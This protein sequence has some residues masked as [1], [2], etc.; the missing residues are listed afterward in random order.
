MSLP[1]DRFVADILA[2]QQRARRVAAPAR[3]AVRAPK[4]RRDAPTALVLSP[5]PDDEC[6][7]GGL[8]LRLREEGWRVVNITVTLGSRVERRAPRRR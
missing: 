3:T 4:P 7:I 1:F 6:I 5:H 8:A 2:A